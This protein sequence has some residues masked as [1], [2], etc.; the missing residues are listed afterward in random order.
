MCPLCLFLSLFFFP[1]SLFFLLLPLISFENSGDKFKEIETLFHH[2]IRR[3]SWGNEE[4]KT[5]LKYWCW[6]ASFLFFAG[7]LSLW[8]MAEDSPFQEKT[9]SSMGHWKP[10]LLWSSWDLLW[11]FF[12]SY[13]WYLYLHSFLFWLLNPGRWRSGE[14]LESAAPLISHIYDRAEQFLDF[15]NW[16]KPILNNI[17]LIL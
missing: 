6:N 11:V 1:L 17:Y 8:K 12:Y 9:S 7:F 16:Y 3:D 14:R 13:W 4:R 5:Q 10:S 15:R 2:G